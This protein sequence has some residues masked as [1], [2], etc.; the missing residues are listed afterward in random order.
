MY[1]NIL[2]DEAGEDSAI[3]ED[4]QLIVE[5]SERCKTIVAGLLNFARKNQVNHTEINLNDL[6]RKSLSSVII[7]QKVKLEILSLLKNPFAEL[8][9]EQMVQVISNLVKNAVEAMP[10]G[11]NINIELRDKDKEITIVIMDS[12]TGINEGDLEKVFEPF[13]TTK[14][15]GKGTGLGLAT[16]YGVLKMHKGNISVESNSDPTSGPT[17]TK[18]IIKL[19]R[20]RPI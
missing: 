14:G 10:G 9:G 12:G 11:G 2:L 1:A 16:A 18:F 20:R 4:L 19:P 5:Q 13:F 7:P 3:R 15:I 8:D 6:I 17:F